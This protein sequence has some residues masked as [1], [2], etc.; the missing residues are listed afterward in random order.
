MTAA[1]F[2][3]IAALS[4]PHDILAGVGALYRGNLFIRDQR[5]AM[6]AYEVWCELFGERLE[7]F[8]DEALAALVPHSD[9]FLIGQEVIDIGDR[10][11]FELLPKAR[12]YLFAPMLYAC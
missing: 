10:N 5:V 7:R 3:D 8:V 11:E 1:H 9:V 2:K 12:A 4:H 6:D